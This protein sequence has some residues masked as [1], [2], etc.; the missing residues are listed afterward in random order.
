MTRLRAPLFVLACLL[1]CLTSGISAQEVSERHARLAVS[2]NL[3]DD[4]FL[5]TLNADAQYAILRH[6]TLGAGA[7]Y[8]NWT[9]R[10]R[11]DAQFESRQK[12]FYVGTRW[13][14]WYTYSGWW[15]GAKIQY[16]EYNRGGL[17]GPETEEGDAFGLSLGGGYAVHV[18]AWFNV[19]FGLYGWTGVTRYVT[20]ACPY[21]GKRTDAGTKAFLLPDEVRVAL[22]FIF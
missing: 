15:S 12:T 20:Y 1:G 13:W 22:Q 7:R 11:Q 2:Q 8:N 14:P 6:W 4:L 18:N 10:Y 3:A 5:G 16:Q 9:W 17:S 21:C 19:E